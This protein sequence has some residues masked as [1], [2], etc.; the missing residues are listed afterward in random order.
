MLPD[1]E[2]DDPA[3]PVDE[4]D[5]DIASDPVDS[6]LIRPLKSELR[7]DPTGPPAVQ[8]ALGA[9]ERP[10]GRGRHARAGRC[11]RSL[12]P[13][14][15]FSRKTARSATAAATFSDCSTMI[16][17]CPRR[18]EPLDDFEQS[19]H[20]RRAR[21]PSD[22]SSIS[23]ISGSCMQHACER[24]ASAAGHPRGS[25]A[26]SLRAL[27]SVGNRSKHVGRSVARRP[28]SAPRRR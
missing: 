18:L 21:G 13:H 6:P 19:L 27:A 12:E 3:R 25:P 17:V 4:H 8:P 26:V 16:I 23:R 20:D 11:A 9:E 2:V 7:R 24:R 1:G 28:S 15:P 22:S 10:L 5:A 14:C